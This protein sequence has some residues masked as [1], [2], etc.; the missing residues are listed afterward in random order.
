MK[1]RV[2][3]EKEEQRKAVDFRCP[4]CRCLLSISM[5]QSL[6]ETMARCICGKLLELTD[7]GEEASNEP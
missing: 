2:V 7:I 6:N 1:V 4:S 5:K 3:K